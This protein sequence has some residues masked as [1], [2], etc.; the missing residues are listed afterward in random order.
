MGNLIQ[1][2]R[3]TW[4]ST[5]N[6]EFV[7]T[8]YQV[9]NTLGSKKSAIELIGSHIIFLVTMRVQAYSIDSYLCFDIL[10]RCFAYLKKKL[11][12]LS[13]RYNPEQHSILRNCD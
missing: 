12:K 9:V 13:N 5:E 3:D 7:R 11:V 8:V 2:R 6:T 1:T 10:I 4:N